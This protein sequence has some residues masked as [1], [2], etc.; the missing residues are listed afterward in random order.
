MATVAGALVTF[1]EADVSLLARVAAGS[2]SALAE[3][4]DLH[5]DR[6]Y[7]FA[8]RLVGEDAAAEDLLHDVFIALPAAARRYRGDA[9]IRT[10]LLSIALNH[11]RHHI[12]A[13]MRRRAAIHRFGREPE[14]AV[15]TPHHEAHRR[16]LAA[17]LSRALDKLPMEQ[18]V[19][20]VLCD[21]EEQT[22]VEAATVVGVPESTVRTRL[23]H[24]RKKLRAM[25]EE[26]EP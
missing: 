15:A 22:S 3:V 14:A 5:A 2:T 6:V 18:R 23:F 11:A 26:D 19:A 25:L 12:R 13:A 17:R 4:Y 10:F 20:F 7:G 1:G 8:R 16:E 24:A 21:V 9:P